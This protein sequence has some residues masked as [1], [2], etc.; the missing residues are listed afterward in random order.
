MIL[1]TTDKKR[2]KDLTEEEELTEELTKAMLK[3]GEKNPGKCDV[4]VNFGNGQ[5]IKIEHF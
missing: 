3:I 4:T 1:M 2:Q 5:K